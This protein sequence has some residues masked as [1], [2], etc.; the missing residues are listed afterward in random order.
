M[1]PTRPEI[2][3]GPR[4]AVITGRPVITALKVSR[5]PAQR[6]VALIRRS[7]EPATQPVAASA[8]GA[9][10]ATAQTSEIT[11]TAGRHVVSLRCM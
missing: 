8:T 11:T 9:R 10:L 4:S 2:A 6:T 7:G 3:A 5:P 1:T